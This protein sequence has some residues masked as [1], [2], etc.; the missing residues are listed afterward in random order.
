MPKKGLLPVPRIVAVLAAL[1]WL[2]P[3]A[4][5][6]QSTTARF[7]IYVTEGDFNLADPT[8]SGAARVGFCG[9]L[10]EGKERRGVT[11][12]Q[13]L[14]RDWKQMWVSFVA[15]G[16]GRVDIQL[17]GEWYAQEGPEDVRLIWADQ[18]EV[19]G[20]K[21]SNG[22]F[23]DAGADGWPA[24]W[25][26]PGA[27]DATHYSRDGSVA[28]SGKSCLAIWIGAAA[29]QTFA[30]Q[31]GQRYT[32]RAWFRVLDPSAIKEPPH[33]PLEFPAE[34]Y[35]QELEVEFANE[36]A[37]RQAQVELA[38]LW[39]D[40]AWAVSS[41]WDDNNGEDVKM[42]DV[43]NAHGHRGTFYL[44]SLWADWDSVTTTTDSQ[45]GRDILQGGHS[46]GGHSLTHPLLSY[47][48]R[49]RIFEETAGVR[50]VWEAATDKPV[51]SYSFSY[52][53]FVNPQEGLEVQA[54]IARC[55][56]R[57]GFYHLANEHQWEALNTELMLSPIMPSDGLD[58]DSYVEGVMADP[59]FKQK[60]PNLTYSM[61]VWYR[62][63][64][65][66]AK[67]E[68]QL[69]KYGRRPDWWYCN[70]NEYAAY[71]YQ[72]ARTKLSTKREGKVVRVTLERPV[73][74]DLNDATPLTLKVVGVPRAQVAAV[75][76]RT[77]ECVPSAR[78]GDGYVF[79]LGHDRNQGLPAKIG[80]IKPNTD[81]HK[82]LT[83]TD[84]DT[85]F[86]GLRALL[87][88]DNG[89]LTL[90]LDNQGQ[91][92]LRDVRVT[93]RLPLAY[94]E[95]VAWRRVADVA[96]HQQRTALFTPTPALSDYKYTAGNQFMI[97]QVDFV[98]GD[99][100]GRLHLACYPP[101]VAVDHAYPQ[102]G[103]A[104][105]GPI[106][107]EQIDLKHVIADLQSGQVQM[108]AWVLPDD[109]RLEWRTGDS[110]QQRPWPDVEMPRA[111]GDWFGKGHYVLL[112][113]TL[114]SKVQQTV[115]LR[116]LQGSAAALLLNG[117]DVLG[118]KTVDLRQGPNELC[119]VTTDGVGMYL[120]VQDPAS[121]K[122]ITSVQFSPATPQ[123]Q[124]E[125]YRPV[126]AGPATRKALAGKWRGKLTVKLPSATAAQTH[127]DRGLSEEA[128]RAVLPEADDT[129]WA[130]LEVPMRW[131]TYGGEWSACD[132]EAVFRRTVIIPAE[133]AG[134]DLTLSLGPI[135]D[136]DDTFFN[137]QLVGRTDGTVPDFYSAPRQYVVPATLVKPGAN[138]LAVRI[139]DHF[140]DGGFTGATTDMFIAPK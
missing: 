131:L 132:G 93:Y 115:Q 35:R 136:F 26:V 10:G 113:G 129:A 16:D 49:N 53:N 88:S 3:Y 82:V 13:P 33:V 34:T 22:D 123:P 46:I 1:T 7:D 102:G 67:F 76:C 15:E 42:R 105:L 50:M 68:A 133:W 54:D 72:Y 19:D 122:R 135:D 138:V 139:F 66:W 107:K 43:L 5:G 116:C 11:V 104:R 118:A 128:K 84:Q 56:Q 83:A 63:P 112:R 37:A 80:L 91:A 12:E 96:A 62:T 51:V 79:S 14:G 98:R 85:D 40:R 55:L 71:R 134:R 126:A 101:P 52:C 45:F 137:G 59:E 65:A 95:G 120:R 17:Q 30:V 24:G 4:Y 110:P 114:N 81:N 69:D 92:P 87:Y 41:R 100:R 75:R 48:N 20:A 109:T 106:P 47:C 29:H 31:K 2:S 108:Q 23:E 121:G 39:D 89:R 97:A 64:E 117:Q 74:L 90:V 8:G 9:W 27:F 86:P 36:A 28:H 21:I 44:N 18:V 6:A 61:H 38:P 103:F 70:E 32:V 78:A 99:E 127:P 140:G 25:R 58:I 111:G 124:A 94:K 77:A 73:L 119:L 57:G 125:A 130:E 60:H